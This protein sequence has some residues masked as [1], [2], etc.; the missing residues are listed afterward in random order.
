MQKLYLQYILLQAWQC[1][2]TKSLINNQKIYIQIHTWKQTSCTPYE[3]IITK[4]DKYLDLARELRKLWNMS[5]TMVPIV[6]GALGSQ[7]LGKGA[8]RVGNQ[9]MNQDSLNYSIVEIDQNTEKSPG[10]LRRLTVTQTSAKGYQLTLMW[11][12]H[13]ENNNNNNNNN[14][15]WINK[16]TRK[17]WL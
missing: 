10:D 1:H 12:T 3:I 5:V 13:E 8:W 16:I 9:R 15:N 11:T 2:K 17:C 6:I 14:N 7:R 4:I